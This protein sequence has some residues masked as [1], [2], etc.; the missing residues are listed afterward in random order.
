MFYWN[1]DIIVQLDI[2]ILVVGSWRSANTTHKFGAAIGTKMAAAVWKL[3][4]KWRTGR[5]ALDS[6]FETQN[7][8]RGGPQTAVHLD[9]STRAAVLNNRF[10]P[11]EDKEQQ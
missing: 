8:R 6:L 9:P 4:R 10:V 7:E 3:Y 11:S 5:A 1:I 2:E